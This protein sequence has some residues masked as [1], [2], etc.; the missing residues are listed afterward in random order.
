M[1][2]ETIEWRKIEGYENY[3]VS[4]AGEVR[5]DETGLILKPRI[6]TGYLMLYLHKNGERKTHSVHRL[7]ALSFIPNPEN[8]RCV[9]HKDNNPLN[10]KLENLR[11]ATIYEN[12]ANAKMRSHNTSG[13][14]GVSWYKR[15]SKWNVQIRINGVKTNLGYFAT[16]EEATTVRRAAAQKYF[17]EFAHFSEKN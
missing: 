8:K 2:D 9:D 7:V 11:W 13:V 6:R 16:L 17:G 5:N 3:S 10:N 14:K 4:S 15:Y 12:G 1:T